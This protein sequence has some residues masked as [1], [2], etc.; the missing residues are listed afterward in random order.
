[1][2]QLRKKL[3]KGGTLFVFEPNPLYLSWYGL[4]LIKGILSLEKGILN[5]NIWNLKKELEKAG[6]K[7]ITIKPYGLL[8]T[9]LL[10][11][12]FFLLEL[13]ALKLSSLPLLRLFV[14]HHLIKAEK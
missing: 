7:K 8:P 2:T 1:M 12:S 5:S 4:F 11:W 13:T 3:K 10:S 9:R 14:F 6:F